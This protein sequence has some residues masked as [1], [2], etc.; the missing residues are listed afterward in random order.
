MGDYSRFPTAGGRGAEPAARPHLLH[1]YLVAPLA[2]LALFGGAVT[3]AA[4]VR[5]GK[6]GM[7]LAAGR[8]VADYEYRRGY[9]DGRDEYANLKSTVTQAHITCNSHGGVV[10]SN[11]MIEGAFFQFDEQALKNMIVCFDN[12]ARER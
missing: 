3:D 9:E 7:V 11:F 4:L 10:I 8:F 6:S 2:L 12:T 1:P 5:P